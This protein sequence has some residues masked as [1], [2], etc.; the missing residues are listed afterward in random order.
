MASVEGRTP[1]IYPLIPPG[2]SHRA[3]FLVINAEGRLAGQCYCEL[4]TGCGCW[5][6]TRKKKE[7]LIKSNY[8]VMFWQ[9]LLGINYVI[10]LHKTPFIYPGGFPPLVHRGFLLSKKVVAYRLGYDGSGERYCQIL[11]FVDKQNQSVTMGKQG[12]IFG[13]SKEE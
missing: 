1:R 5:D 12:R 2:I 8:L 13:N 10:V 11:L 3:F 6:I 7:A 4:F 9:Y